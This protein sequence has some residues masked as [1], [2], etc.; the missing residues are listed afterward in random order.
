[1]QLFYLIDKEYGMWWEQN[2]GP[3]VP[4]L[5]TLSIQSL[6]LLVNPKHF[7]CIGLIFLVKL[8]KIT[9][10]RSRYDCKGISVCSHILIWDLFFL[11]KCLIFE[12]KFHFLLQL[13]TFPLRYLNDLKTTSKGLG[14]FCRVCLCSTYAYVRVFIRLMRFAVD[15][16]MQII[17]LLP[18][19]PTRVSR[20]L[21]RTFCTTSGHNNSRQLTFT[22][23]QLACLP[24]AQPVPSHQVFILLFCLQQAFLS[25]R[26]FLLTQWCVFYA[27]M[28]EGIMLKIRTYFIAKFPRRPG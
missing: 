24:A 25:V 1:M 22:I 11:H 20:F 17:F 2:L 21:C 7:T 19:F 9:S 8:K 4:N 28:E 5:S 10:P 23:A 27:L 18:L 16:Y 12:N 6:T 15:I 26:V 14:K 3:F 13:L